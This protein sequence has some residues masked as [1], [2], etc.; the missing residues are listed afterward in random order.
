MPHQPIPD[1]PITPREWQPD[2]KVII[3][4]DD[5]CARAWE[6]ENDKRTLYRNPRNVLWN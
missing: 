1:K 2:P 6:C 5:L 4:H 3:T